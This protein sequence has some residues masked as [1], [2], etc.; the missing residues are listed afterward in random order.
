M[1]KEFTI[2]TCAVCTEPLRVPYFTLCYACYN[3]YR[4]QLKEPWM[5]ELIRIQRRQD[6]ITSKE[7]YSLVPYKSLDT[8]MVPDN[9]Q[10]TMP[11]E[12]AEKILQL[13]DDSIDKEAC[14]VGKRISLRKIQELIGNAV[15][16]ITIR[17]L[18]MAYRKETYM[19]C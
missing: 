10:Y 2:K 18:L 1:R 13:Y 4:D 7:Q 16:Y 14:G 11:A 19:K 3:Q 12:L 8:R 5:K 9:R 6:A 17:S 15:S